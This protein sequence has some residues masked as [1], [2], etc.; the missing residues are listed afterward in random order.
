MTNLENRRSGLWIIVVVSV[1]NYAILHM[2]GGDVNYLSL[3][4]T[5]IVIWGLSIAVAIYE[6][7]IAIVE[8]LEAK[9]EK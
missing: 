5:T 2:I 7:G 4:V 3:I 1:A 6:V 9:G 8:R